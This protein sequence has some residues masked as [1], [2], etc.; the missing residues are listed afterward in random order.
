MAPVADKLELFDAILRPCRLGWLHV[1][2][3]VAQ[4]TGLLRRAPKGFWTRNQGKFEVA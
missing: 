3:V 4:G 2:R 1:R